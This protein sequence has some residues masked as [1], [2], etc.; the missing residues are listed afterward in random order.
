MKKLLLELVVVANMS[1]AMKLLQCCKRKLKVI[2]LNRFR[3]YRDRPN[4]V[5]MQQECRAAVK[6]GCPLLMIV[7]GIKH[8]FGNRGI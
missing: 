5:D 4:Y 3:D 8:F 2:K 1:Y 6:Y 7:A